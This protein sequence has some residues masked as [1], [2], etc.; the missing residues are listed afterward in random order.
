MY[1][2]SILSLSEMMSFIG[3]NSKRRDFAKL[4]LDG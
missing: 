1:Q 3:T 2:K 4:I